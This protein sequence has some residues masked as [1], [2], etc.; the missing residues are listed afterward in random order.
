[1]LAEEYT[2]VLICTLLVNFLRIFII[3]RRLISVNY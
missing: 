3:S 2:Q 1:M